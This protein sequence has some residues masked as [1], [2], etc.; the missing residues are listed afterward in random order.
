MGD[1]T[2]HNKQS[3]PLSEVIYLSRRQW[4]LRLDSLI[5]QS[6]S[7]IIV[8]F[9][10]LVIPNLHIVKHFCS[11][12]SLVILIVADLD[13]CWGVL[14]K[15]Y[16]VALSENWLLNLIICHKEQCMVLFCSCAWL[17]IP[18]SLHQ[19]HMWHLWMIQ[20]YGKQWKERTS[21]CHDVT[22]VIPSS[23]IFGAIRR[24]ELAD[25]LTTRWWT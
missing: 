11:F 20:P 6:I 8:L 23:Q 2:E 3:L 14:Q 13:S 17:M 10:A 5:Y 1:Y 4:Y 15:N 21:C 9:C 16:S 24:H 22:D 19:Q 25:V 12:L 18:N 7:D